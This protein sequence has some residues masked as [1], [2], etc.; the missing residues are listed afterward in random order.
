MNADL[1]F[2]LTPEEKVLFNTKSNKTRL[3]RRILFS[4]AGLF[5]SSVS[6]ILFQI[7]E[8]SIW[9]ACGCLCLGIILFYLTWL[10][11]ARSKHTY[12]QLTDKR[13]MVIELAVLGG[14]PTVFTFPLHAHLIQ[15]I[16]RHRNGNFD[17]LFAQDHNSIV[18]RGGIGFYN[19]PAE[20]FSVEQWE[21]LGCDIPEKNVA[22][23]KLPKIQRPAGLRNVIGC[24][25][26]AIIL[27]GL[28]YHTLMES[29]A[30]LHFF[31]KEE[32]A[33]IIGYEEGT[34]KRGKRR[35]V[36]IYYP[37]VIYNKGDAYIQ[38]TAL[39]GYAEP[40]T[41]GE[42]TTVLAD[43]QAPS[44]VIPAEGADETVITPAVFAIACLGLAACFVLTTIRLYRSRKLP[45]HEV[46][47][48]P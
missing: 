15:R 35:E 43:E 12:Y 1:T 45:F 29:G 2:A 48:T 25:F 37:I 3:G 40:P 39:A 17:Y 33:L 27:G 19:L 28:C 42:Y 34:E 7:S 46:K 24:L 13:A 4:L 11:A 47:V 20:V 41:M 16:K 8:A 38:T 18:S 21:N 14:K 31:G 9:L 32:K 44:R 23:K 30:D 22:V 26:G 36:T 5:L 10:D 6:I